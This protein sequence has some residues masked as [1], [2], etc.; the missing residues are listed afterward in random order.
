MDRVDFPMVDVI[1]LKPLSAHRLR[2][3]FTTGEE[4]VHD[5]STLKQRTGSMIVPLHDEAF[6]SRVF[7]EMGAPTWPNSFDV[8]PIALYMETRAAGLLKTPAAVE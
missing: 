8:D 1:K 4:G 7:V 3:R 6:F 5:F 2:V